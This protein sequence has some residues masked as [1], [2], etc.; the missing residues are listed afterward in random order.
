[1]SILSLKL[2]LKQLKENHNQS[3]SHQK[4]TN[5]QA[6]LRRQRILD[7]MESA[8]DTIDTPFEA[9][10]FFANALGVVNTPRA[11]ANYLKPSFNS[12]R[13]RDEE[14]EMALKQGFRL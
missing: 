7:Q 2:R 11:L 6:F 9:A 8:L 4:Q 3:Q 1:M 10:I 5:Q 14:E 13:T 12:R